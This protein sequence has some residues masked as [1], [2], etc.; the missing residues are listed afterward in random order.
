[1]IIDILIVGVFSYIEYLAIR[2]L[3][4]SIESPKLYTKKNNL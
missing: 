2:I 1:M 4:L 3:N